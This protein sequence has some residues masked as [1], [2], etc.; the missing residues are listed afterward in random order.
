MPTATSCFLDG[1]EAC[2]PRVE[3]G[4]AGRGTAWP[5]PGPWG[6]QGSWAAGSCV[7]LWPHLSPSLPAGDLQQHLQAMFIL[8]RPEDN[9]RLVGWLLAS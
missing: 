6:R 2:R 1:R 8:L 5:A 3:T 7:G 9:I 4:G